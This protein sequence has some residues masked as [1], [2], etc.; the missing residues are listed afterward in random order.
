MNTHTQIQPRAIPVYR[1][2]GAPDLIPSEILLASICKAMDRVAK[3]D[4]K[5]ALKAGNISKQDPNSRPGGMPIG[6]RLA[7]M[8]E[9]APMERAT[10]SKMS[11]MKAD[12]VSSGLNV[13][14]KTAMIKPNYQTIELTPKGQAWLARQKGEPVTT[15][16]KTDLARLAVLR[17]ID[18][19]ATTTAQVAMALGKD[20]SQVGGRIREMVKHNMLLAV[21]DPRNTNFPMLLSMTVQGRKMLEANK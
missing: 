16:D 3:A 4:M 2:R 17:A 8:V 1:D 14:R 21:H 19:G 6:L 20:K 9:H 10:L 5:A 7:L 18:T 15:L 12:T 13:L 11:G